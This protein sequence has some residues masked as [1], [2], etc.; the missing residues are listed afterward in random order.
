MTALYIILGIIL[1][2]FLLLIIPVKVDLR[3]EDGVFSFVLYYGFMKVYDSTKPKKE[4]PE[5]KK[6]KKKQEKKT[7]KEKKP[8]TASKLFA[9]KKAE[10]SYER[11]R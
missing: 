6:K 8:S 3:F 2:F 10:S 9:H 1:F 11:L 7:E 4:K 5:K